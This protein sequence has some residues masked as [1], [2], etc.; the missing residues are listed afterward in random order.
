MVALSRKYLRY[1]LIILRPG[2]TDIQTPDSTLSLISMIFLSGSLVML[3]F[4][5]LS[6]LTST[7][8]LRQTH[9]LQADTSDITGARPISQWTYFFICGPDNTDCGPAHPA[10]PF[11]SAWSSNPSKAPE[12]LVGHYGSGTTSFTYWYMWRFGWVFFL[13]ALFFEVLTFFS[14]FLACCSRLGSA[15]SGLIALTALL[16]YTVA[17]SL[18]TYVF[19]PILSIPSC[20]G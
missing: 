9:F 6:G 7:S 1:Q 10:L 3:W 2:P 13:I 19:V 16:F 18:M 4:I 12:E 15:I 17:V 14:G 8:P 5:I 20:D 11:G